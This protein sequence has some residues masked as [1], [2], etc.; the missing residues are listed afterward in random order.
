MAAIIEGSTT[1]RE[2][3][4]NT[5]ANFYLTLV[6]QSKFLFRRKLLTHILRVY[7]FPPAPRKRNFTKVHADPVVG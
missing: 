2:E 5:F 3:L 1:R 7:S 6:G 4:I